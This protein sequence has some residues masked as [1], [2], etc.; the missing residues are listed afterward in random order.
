VRSRAPDVSE[1][2]ASLAAEARSAIA[3]ATRVAGDLESVVAHLRRAT[4]DALPNADPTAMACELRSVVMHAT[5]LLATLQNASGRL[6]V[7]AL[8]FRVPKE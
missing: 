8:R 3:E 7:T 5:A 6:D 2:E 4:L 1:L